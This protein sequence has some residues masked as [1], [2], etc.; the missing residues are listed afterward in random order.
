MKLFKTNH[1]D[2][3]NY[4]CMQYNLELPSVTIAQR[5]TKLRISIDCVTMLFVSHLYRIS[6]ICANDVLYFI[7]F[8]CF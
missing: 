8:L 5:S 6:L 7:I 2:I 1:I 4:C 3:V